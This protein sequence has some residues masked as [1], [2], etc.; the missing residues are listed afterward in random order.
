MSH[1][2]PTRFAD[3]F[4]GRLSPA[5]RAAD[6][7]HVRGCSRCAAEQ[8]RVVRASDSFATIRA[9][10]APELPWDAV[11]ARVHWEVS[12]EKRLGTGELVARWRWPWTIAG[13]AVAAG[14][15]ALVVTRAD[16]PAP[17]PIAH[18]PAAS[19]IAPA[20]EAR[21]R[22]A[23]LVGLVSRS[24]GEIRVDGAP[25]AD[26]YA[27]VLAAGS[28]VATGEGRL[29]VQFGDG[30]ALA[31]GP[32]STVELRR[33]D[34]EA[35]ELV[36]RG[37]LDVE[38][39]PRA[40][41]RERLARRRQPPALGLKGAQLGRGDAREVPSARREAMIGPVGRVRVGI[42]VDRANDRSTPGAARRPDARKQ[43]QQSAA[44]RR[45]LT[46]RARG[47]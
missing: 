15:T 32:R 16:A 28:V 38:V 47:R 42:L 33:F 27:R 46:P 44:H 3:A 5:E 6:E 26:L 24:A 23:P 9:L 19:R 21:A 12:K 7:A 39:A 34:A 29:D 30:S 4:A 41:H 45:K 18:A 40:P 36:V 10:P 17:A 37:T 20:P 35:V 2:A 8:A 22:P 1:V 11:R 14:V 13:L 31:L 43:L 25:V